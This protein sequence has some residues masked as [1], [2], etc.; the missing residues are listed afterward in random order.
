MQHFPAYYKIIDYSLKTLVQGRAA[1]EDKNYEAKRSLGFTWE[2]PQGGWNFIKAANPDDPIFTFHK[3][4]VEHVSK[5]LQTLERIP[6]TYAQTR[7]ILDGNSVSGLSTNQLR[8]IENYAKACEYISELIKNNKFIFNKEILCNIHSIVAKDEVRY[9]GEF[10]NNQVLIEKSSYIP[11][12]PKFLEK[13]FNEGIHF[14]ENMNTIEEKAV[15]SFLFLSRSQFFADCNK[16]TANLIMNGLLMKNGYH[17]VSIEGYDFNEKIAKFYEAADATEIIEE[18][19]NIAKNQYHIEEKNIESRAEELHRDQKYLASQEYDEKL[20][21]YT[22]AKMKSAERLEMN[23]ENK[24][25]NQKSKLTDLERSKPGY[26]LFWRKSNWEAIFTEERKRL[27][28]LEK[29]LSRVKM[30]RSEMNGNY[31]RDLATKKLR[32]RE[33]ELSRWRDEYVQAQTK[34]VV[35][36]QHEC[37]QQEQNH[38]LELTRNIA[39]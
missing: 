35:S 9:F 12:Q 20:K 11:P 18:I 30:L 28:H 38:S 14:L 8:A 29:R 21:I 39:R 37:R 27:I 4:R 1:M 36:Q 22:D 15:C 13:I 31:L 32:R 7:A 10:R 34:Q 24:I 2:V 19:N 3:Y 23:L 25:S 33:K 16:R 26:F 17:P 6:C 5:T